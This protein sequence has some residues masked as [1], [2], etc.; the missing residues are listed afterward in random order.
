MSTFS[1]TDNA[2]AGFRVIG[3]KPLSFVAWLVLWLVVAV[4]PVMLLM[5]DLM[6]KILAF[7]TEAKSWGADAK[8]PEALSRV[9]RFQMELFGAMGPWIGLA[10]VLQLILYAA[11]CRAMLEPRKSAFAY[12]RL[13]LDELRLLATEILIILLAIGGL[14]MMSLACVALV[15]AGQAAGHPWTG[16]IVGLGCLAL[17]C[18]AI[19][20]SVRLSLALP[21][22]FADKRI[23]I[24]GSWR[25]TK[26]RFWSLLGMWALSFIFVIA[27]M[28]VISV[29]QRVAFAGAVLGSGAWPDIKHLVE[30]AGANGDPAKMLPRLFQALGP[31]LLIVILLQGVAQLV[32]RIVM[33]APFV[34]AYAG[35]SAGRE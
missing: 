23:N 15:F 27:L 7:A 8:G 34:C 29:V 2:T 13:G 24:F 18:A 4:V 17:I 26:G 30:S 35:L 3:R 32:S 1:I 10:L 20:V 28:L 21:Q 33:A 19:W 6:P 31:A 22:T 25:L 12:V 16:W 9:M 5:A 14:L 11:L